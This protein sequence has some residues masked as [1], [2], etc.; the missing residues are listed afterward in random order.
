M[1]DEV[2]RHGGRRRLPAGKGRA[3]QQEL[4]HQYSGSVAT[5]PSVLQVGGQAECKEELRREYHL[6]GLRRAGEGCLLAPHLSA[7]NPCSIP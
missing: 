3:E 4:P 7:L 1:I 2:Y 5:Y 6:Q